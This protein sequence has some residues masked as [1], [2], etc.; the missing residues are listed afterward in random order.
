[1]AQPTFLVLPPE[2]RAAIFDLLLRDE[3]PAPCSAPPEVDGEPRAVIMHCPITSSPLLRTSQQIR[4]EV[5]AAIERLKL[6]KQLRYKAILFHTDEKYLRL[7]WTSIPAKS[8]CVDRIDIDVLIR[9]YWSWFFTG[10][11]TSP[12]FLKVFASLPRSAVLNIKIPTPTV[13]PG[14]L[15]LLPFE[16]PPIRSRSRLGVIHPRTVAAQIADC[17]TGAAAHGIQRRP[18]PRWLHE[19][20]DKLT[21]S[22]DEGFAVELDSVVLAGWSRDAEA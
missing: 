17:V 8:S 22:T 11:C 19:I 20:F 13:A 15:E 16:P 9:G 1:M 2:I 4:I 12:L 21:I 5:L 14:R 3:P 10:T 7:I 18:G 6:R